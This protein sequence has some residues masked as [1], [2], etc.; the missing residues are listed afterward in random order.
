[1]G[2]E[3]E[4]M[5]AMHAITQDWA[6]AAEACATTEE[7]TAVWKVAIKELQ[8]AGDKAEYVRV[9]AAVAKRGKELTAIAVEHVAPMTEEEAEAANLARGV[10]P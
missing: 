3:P 7:V 10:Q 4:P 6:A 5:V 8:A 9:K 1:M 2:A